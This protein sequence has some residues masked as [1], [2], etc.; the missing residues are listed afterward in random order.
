M[1]KQA[2]R[3]QQ[4]GDTT[5]VCS[6]GYGYR[7]QEA[8]RS[9][10]RTISVTVHQYGHTESSGIV[11]YRLT[12][13]TVMQPPATPP[14][15]EHISSVE[16]DSSHCGGT[17]MAGSPS[18]RTTHLSQALP[19]ALPSPTW[20]CPCPSGTHAQPWTTPDIVRALL[21]RLACANGAGSPPRWRSNT[22][23]ITADRIKQSLSAR[24]AMP[25]PVEADLTSG[26]ALDSGRS[27]IIET[28][29]RTGRAL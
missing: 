18:G 24:S 13:S 8:H 11:D 23:P 20:R 28:T 26:A 4:H 5:P 1:D 27:L 2:P 25:Q 17:E 12:A 7:G 19:E 3:D 22:M 9:D 15:P 16:W 14:T 21:A 6:M 10:V 29:W